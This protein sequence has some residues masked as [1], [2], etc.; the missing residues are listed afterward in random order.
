MTSLPEKPLIETAYSYQRYKIL[1]K[2]TGLSLKT[3][4]FVCLRFLK[5]IFLVI[6]FV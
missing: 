5:P 4:I 1:E 3:F 2:Q 6:S